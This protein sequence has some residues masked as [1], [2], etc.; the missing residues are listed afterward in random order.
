M[1]IAAWL[2]ALGLRQHEQ[3]FRE[4]DPDRLTSFGAWK[5][6]V[7]SSGTN[8]SRTTRSLLPA[9]HSPLVYHVSRISHCDSRRKLAAFQAR[10]WG[11]SAVR[12]SPPEPIM[13]QERTIQATTFEVFAQHEI[14]C[15][16]KAMS[17][18]LDALAVLAAASVCSRQRASRRVLTT[19]PEGRTHWN[20]CNNLGSSWV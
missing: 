7:C 20:R 11:R 19:G 5:L 2:D 13:R 9:P 3:A 15:E 18:W 4:N 1:D 17:Q 14:G 16:L 12:P 10:H 8:T 6:K